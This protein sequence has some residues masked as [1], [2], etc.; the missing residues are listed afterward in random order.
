[1]GNE[2]KNSEPHK[3]NNIGGVSSLPKLADAVAEFVGSIPL[4]GRIH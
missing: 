1:M 4:A 2:Q 3:V